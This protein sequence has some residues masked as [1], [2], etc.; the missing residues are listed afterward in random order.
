MSASVAVSGVAQATHRGQ[1]ARSEGRPI[2]ASAWI[3]AMSAAVASSGVAQETQMRTGV[4]P[5]E[6]RGRPIYAS[7]WIAAMS[8]S[9][10]SSGVA[11]ETQ[12]R[13]GV[14]PSL[15]GAQ[16]SKAKSALSRA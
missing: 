6:A 3:A 11:Q 12:M 2:Y 1:P 14:R 13:M 9:V 10:A 7:A 16:G 8:A 5:S 15:D 4:S